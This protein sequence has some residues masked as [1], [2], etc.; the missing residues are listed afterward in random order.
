MKWTA[1]DIEKLNVVTTANVQLKASDV[2]YPAPITISE[3]IVE[4]TP[5]GVNQA[6]TGKRYKTTKYKNYAKELA[7]K[8][9]PIIRMPVQGEKLHLIAT[10]YV[11]GEFDWD[12][13]IKPF[14]DV[15]AKKLCINDKIIKSGTI[16]LENV[17][18]GKEKIEYKLITRK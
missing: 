9:K 8:L 15:L 4:I 10:F 2:G 3:G 13:P 6:Y 12:N 7:T 1:K 5:I 16:I 14:Q 18:P 17:E 11:S